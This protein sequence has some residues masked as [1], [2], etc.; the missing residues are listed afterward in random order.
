MSPG[1]P[2]FTPLP[3]IPSMSRLAGVLAQ[4]G[5]MIA[6]GGATGAGSDALSGAGGSGAAA[7]PASQF[8]GSAP[9]DP[10]EAEFD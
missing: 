7:L 4:L 3:A 5:G 1:A 10:S 6:G 2:Q 8:G 9:A